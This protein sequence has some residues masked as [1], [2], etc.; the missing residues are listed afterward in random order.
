MQNTAEILLGRTR[1]WPVVIGQIEVG[2]AKIEGTM[3]QAA[4]IVIQCAITK[5][6]PHTE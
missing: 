4:R 2:N 3:H 1:R 5:V 6:V